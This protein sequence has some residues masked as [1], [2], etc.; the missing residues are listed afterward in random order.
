VT[1]IALGIV[2]DRVRITEASDDRAFEESMAHIAQLLLGKK[3]QYRSRF[4][5]MKGTADA[6]NEVLNYYE[7]EPQFLTESTEDADTHTLLDRML[8]P[9]GMLWREVKLSRGWRK[10]AIGAMLST[11]VDGSPVALLP[12]FWGYR[13]YDPATGTHTRLNAR[14]EA[15]ISSEA[16][17]FYKPFPLR[18]LTFKDVFK[19]M[20]GILEPSD[21]VLATTA[22]LL[23]ALIGLMP[24]FVYRI[25]FNNVAGVDISL[26][27]AVLTMY[28][29]VIISLSLINMVKNVVTQRV[30]AKIDAPVEAASVM[31]ML[32][33]P[34]PFFRHYASGETANRIAGIQSMCSNITDTMLTAALT[35]VFSLIYIGQIFYLVPSLFWPALLV[36]IAQAVYSQIAV[37]SR[38]RL[39]QARL[40]LNSLLKGL[41]YALLLGI[42]KLRLTGS[43]KRAFSRWAD[44]YAISVGLA[45]NPPVFIKVIPVVAQVITLGGTL[46]IYLV[47]IGSAISVADYMAFTMAFGMMSGA[48]SSMGTISETLV[49]VQSTIPLIKPL[50]DTKPE[51]DEHREDAGVLQGDIELSGVFFRYGDD[52]PLVLSDISLKVEP[53]QYTAIVGK[54]GCGKSTLLKLLLG[55]ETPQ[56]GSVYYDGKDVSSLDPRSLRRN[57]GAVLQDGELFS[58]TIYSNLA[59]T[60]P[61]LT[62]DEAW[63]AAELAGIADDIREMPMGMFTH[64]ADSL[65]ISGGQKQRLLIARVMAAKPNIVLLD[66]ATSALDNISQHKVAES[67]KN[68]GCT[69]IV[70]AHRLSTIRD[71]DRIVVLDSGRI[72]EDGTYDELISLNGTFAELVKRQRLDA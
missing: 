56:M 49:Q 19:F 58:G 55:F 65:G 13:V 68:M 38:R 1:G 66:E 50:L 29:G 23:A 69:R 6:V 42:Q 63:E 9:S 70:I 4:A 16:I 7:C 45:Y 12:S 18:K 44:I 17:C 20:L 59:A 27:P 33:L 67:L 60:V 36:L 37:F 57:I 28:A 41:Q 53:G 25:I 62:L 21:Y 3:P 11:R 46:L 34:A 15:K 14:A 8:R 30:R 51:L 2:S 43:E 47:A 64:I 40:E 32:S 26:L 72:V 10:Q 48:I 52:Y 61:N 39:M 22:T 5:S 54:T 31:R 24:A 71:C 35:G